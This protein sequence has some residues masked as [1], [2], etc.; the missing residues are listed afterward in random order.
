MKRWMLISLL[1]LVLAVGLLI[2]GISSQAQDKV[3]ITFWHA[4]GGWRVDFIQRM[5]DDFNLTHP[6]IEVTVEYKGSYR[7]TLNAALA[8]ARAGTAPHV[9]QVFEVGTQQ[10]IDS[11]IFAPVQDL[12]DQFGLVVPWQDYLDPVLNYYRVGGKLYS[13][14][15]NSSNPILYYNK[16]LLDK[17]GVTMPEKPTF[18]DILEIGQK[19]VESGVA[20]AAITWPL[21]SW[22][23]EQWMADMCQDLVNNGN[24]R[25]DYA[26]EINLLSPAAKQIMSWWKELYDKGL[27]INPGRENWAQARQNFISQRSAMLIS[28]TSDVTLMEN[29]AAE[30]GF[31]LG[32]A[33]IPVPKGVDRCGVVIGGASLWITK[34]HPEDELRAAAEFVVWMSQTAQQIRWHQGTGYFPIRKSAVDALELEGWF[35]THPNYSTAFN[36]LLETKPVTATQGALM[37]PFLEART[38]I[39]DA[40]EQV[41]TGTSVEQAL[42]DAKAK[43]DKALEDYLALV[44]S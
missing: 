14:P 30:Q 23:F 21:H 29:A 19:I 20:E 33:Y 3:K 34:D 36:Q 1:V 31:E 9:V 11:G 37:G 28:S 22:F 6:K 35:D 12:T 5:V 41:L 18:E 38:Y 10:N 15:W 4:M 40:V 42:A 25:N 7:D 32:T 2:P 17:A 43:I 24:G 13:M 8:A 44:K 39:E 16:T 26:T 27:W